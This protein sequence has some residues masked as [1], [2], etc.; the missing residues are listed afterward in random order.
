M[1]TQMFFQIFLF[2]QLVSEPGKLANNDRLAEVHRIVDAISPSAKSTRISFRSK[3]FLV[4]FDKED[5]LNLFFHPISTE[6]L[7]EHHLTAELGINTQPQRVIFIPDVTDD[8]IQK[9]SL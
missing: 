2:D 9:G 4:S 5:A 7:K 6:T 8:T 3:G 1:A